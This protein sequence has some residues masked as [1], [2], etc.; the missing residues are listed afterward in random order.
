MVQDNV[1]SHRLNWGFEYSHIPPLDLTLVQRE[2]Y[3]WFLDE[4]IK[5]LLS[6]I[7][8]IADFT[9]TPIKRILEVLKEYIAKHKD[10]SVTV[11]ARMLPS[12]LVP[13]LDQAYLW[14]V[15]SIIDKEDQYLEEWKKTVRELQ[16]SIIR[17]K[18]QDLNAKARTGADSDLQERLSE[19][20]K[21]LFQV[22]KSIWELVDQVLW[23]C[24][25][26]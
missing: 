2:S 3:Q 1:S 15:S 16:R 13:V 4:R 8:P 21:E 22:E 6:E 25:G 24:D 11:F 17:K 14:D 20:T 10:F 5:E 19:L 23:Y 18:I 26:G 12:E 7:S 9:Y